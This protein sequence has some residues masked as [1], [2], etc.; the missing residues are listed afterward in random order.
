MQIIYEDTVKMILFKPAGKLT[1]SNRSFDVDMVSE[2]MTYCRKKKEE[3]YAAVLNRLDRPVSG[4]VLFAKN[5]QE[6]AKLT[7]QMQSHTLDKQYEAVICGKPEL[8]SATFVDYLVK[9]AMDNKS[10]VV[11]E[12]ELSQNSDAK[13]AELNYQV[14]HTFYD[15]TGNVYSH[16]KVTLIT[17]RHHQIRAQFSSRGLPLLGDVKYGGKEAVGIE[18]SKGKPTSNE[19]T[20]SYCAQQSEQGEIQVGPFKRN[21]IAL[22]SVSI[23]VDQKEY[24]CRPSWIHD[25]IEK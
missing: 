18:L 24:H 2:V 4:L 5:K 23:T 8:D 11:T 9:D 6:A 20:G 14:L 15:T 12:A 13:R 25:E 21:E 22:C 19:P 1:Q 3:A 10:H 17:G 16:I 7:K